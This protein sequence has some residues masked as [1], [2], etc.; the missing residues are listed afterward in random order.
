MENSS[1]SSFATLLRHHRT[2]SG[3]SQEALAVR[4]GLSTRAVSDLER[5]LR[6][7]PYRETIRMLADA[8]ALAAADRA[9]LEAAVDRGRGPLPGSRPL[10]EAIVPTLPAA[11]T[12]LIGRGSEAASVRS[13]LRRGEARLVTLTGPPGIGKTRLALA[14]AAALSADFPD[15][16]VF[17]GLAPIADAGLVA[18]TILQALNVHD[19]GGPSPAERLKH[20]LRQK[21][22]LL[23]LD[24]FEQVIDAAPL[25]GELL[26]SC[27]GLS[28][29]ATSRLPLHLRGEHEFPV[30]PLALPDGDT[31]LMRRIDVETL[32]GFPAVALFVARARAVRPDFALT[33]ENAPVVVEICRRLDGLPLAIELAAARCKVLT[34]QAMLGRL[35]HRLRLLTDGARD[36]PERQ[37]TLRAAIAWSHELLSPQERVLFRRLG[38]FVGGCTLGA[39]ERVY[40]AAGDIGARCARRHHGPGRPKSRAARRERRRRAPIRD[41][42]NLAR[43]CPGATR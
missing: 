36:A 21:R 41:A 5:G 28:V 38:V 40:D 20:L 22:M 25:V 8:L 26:E 16:V 39:A 33:A 34:A 12:S 2:A 11:V 17:A 6:R 9:A 14:V 42:G 4:A 37:R 19:I 24:N 32:G 1:A 10:P 27:P 23:V 29:L 35:E 13:Q 7:A 18:A 31:E 15:G 43:V 30:P 3:L